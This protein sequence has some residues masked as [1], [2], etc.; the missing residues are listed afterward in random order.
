MSKDY[1]YTDLP[2]VPRWKTVLYWVII[3]AAAFFLSFGF[4]LLTYFFKLHR[5]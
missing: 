3:L 5:H 4:S 2:K 1:S